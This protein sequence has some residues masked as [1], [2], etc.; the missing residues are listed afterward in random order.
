MMQRSH[1]ALC[2]PVKKIVFIIEELFLIPLLSQANLHGHF[3]HKM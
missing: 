2:V 3:D 1:G